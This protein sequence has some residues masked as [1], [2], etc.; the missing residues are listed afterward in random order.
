MG[1]IE[2]TDG[3]VEHQAFNQDTD[4]VIVNQ[5]TWQAQVAETLGSFEALREYLSIGHLHSEKWSLVLHANMLSSV[6][7]R[8]VRKVWQQFKDNAHVKMRK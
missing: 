4:Q 2:L 8:Q 7:Q 1:Q 6:C 5:V 3:L